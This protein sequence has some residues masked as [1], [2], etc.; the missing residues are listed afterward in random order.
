M[1][2]SDIH[3]ADRGW[4]RSVQL[5]ITD[6]TLLQLIINVTLAF[7]DII[8]HHSCSAYAFVYKKNKPNHDIDTIINIPYTNSKLYITYN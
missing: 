7:R 2:F 1:G 8:I 6:S 4:W 3:V 5:F